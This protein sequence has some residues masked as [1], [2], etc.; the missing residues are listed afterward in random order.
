[1]TKAASA[2]LL[3]LLFSPS[4]ATAGEPKSVAARKVADAPL[5]DGRLDDSAWRGAQPAGEFL[6]LFPDPGKQPAFETDVRV[7]YDDEALYVAARCY[8]SEPGLIVAPVTRRDRD[9]EADWFRIDL[10]TRKDL[11]TGFFFQVNAAGVRTDG[12]LFD[13]N[14][15]STDWDGVW[16]AKVDIDEEGWTVE[17]RIPLRLLRYRGGKEVGFGANFT[18]HISRLNQTDQWQ[19]I[20]PESFL[21]VSRF[22]VLSALDIPD[23]PLRME[24]APYATGRM[25]LGSGDAGETVRPYDLGADARVGL[26]GDFNLTLAANP[27]FGQ[28][29]VDEVVLNLSTIETYYPEKRPFFREDA[30]LFQTPVFQHVT[31]T[32][33]LFYTRRIGRAPRSPETDDDESLVEGARLPRI[34]GAAKVA[35]CTENRLSV[36]LIQAVTSEE[37]ALLESDG[38][39]RFRRVAEPLTSFSVARVKQGFGNNSSAGLTATSTATGEH[40]DAFAGSAD[41]QLEMFDGE[42]SLTAQGFYSHLTQSRFRWHDDFTRTALDE[43]GP[44]GYGS[45]LMFFRKSGRVVGGFIGTHRSPSLA[46]NDLGYIDRADQES[47]SAWLEYR[48]LKPWGP[49]A[50][51]YVGA[52]A[53]LLRNTDELNLGDAAA[54]WLSLSFSNSWE[55]GGVFSHKPGWCDDRETRSPGRAATCTTTSEQELAGWL[56]SDKRLKLWAAFGTVARTTERGHDVMLSLSININP[57]PWLQLELSP[58]YGRTE[59]DIRWIDTE[60]LATGEQ[61]YFAERRT[62]YW[63]LILRTTVSFSTDLTLQTFGQLF[64]AAIDH[65]DKLAAPTPDPTRISIQDLVAAPN[66]ED[67]YDFTSSNLNIGAVLR[68]E[69]LPGSVAYLVYTGAMAESADLA[70]FHVTDALSG[71]NN[72]DSLHTIMLKL[73]YLFGM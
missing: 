58:K 8:D 65:L 47:A 43:E 62:R 45:E 33:E 21:K 28:V 42:Y 36:G 23:K 13:E 19:F 29:E 40:G 27:D 59:G 1:M 48:H 54:M 38:G 3:L 70:H 30:S 35:G 16:E 51:T 15:E 68:W 26:G 57:A 53:W 44:G 18:R 25:N 6:Q 37:S 9:I 64:S 61:F 12:T 56:A 32:P 71:L 10:D 22:G 67:D 73:S 24:L 4:T 69:Y 63:H 34:W 60:D 7:V 66:I 41:L 5:I 31:R 72:E 46:L 50:K 55:L 20:A 52:T 49:V 11:R 17:V 39:S 2:I 14:M